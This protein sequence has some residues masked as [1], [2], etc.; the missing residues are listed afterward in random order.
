MK[1]YHV[2]FYTISDSVVDFLKLENNSNTK[3]SP[4]FHGFNGPMHI[5]DLKEGTK[6]ES[7]RVFIESCKTAGIPIY[8]ASNG[9]SDE[10]IGFTQVH[11]KN[12]KRWSVADGYLTNEVVA[13]PNLFIRL[14]V[15][16][17][18]I[19]IKDQRAIGVEILESG[20]KKFLK[21]NKEV[22]V[23]AGAY[24]SPQLLML[25]GVGP[26]EHLESLGI[27]VVK[28]LPG[29][30]K[31]LQD[32]LLTGVAFNLTQLGGLDTEESLFNLAQ[33]LIVTIIL[34]SNRR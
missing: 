22:I 20:E 19:V 2:T 30:G 4:E 10:G 26:K 24:N 1:C 16:V 17:S 23:S 12:G 33:W 25:S 29:V 8:E 34:V 28:D 7:I 13:R 9:F 18:K 11:M 27:K 14:G 3:L 32:H 15:H 6:H 5:E 31:N 21:A